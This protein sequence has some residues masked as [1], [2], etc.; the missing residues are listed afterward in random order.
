MCV[1]IMTES[2]KEEGDVA[3]KEKEARLL[4]EDELRKLKAEGF[5]R[6]NDLMCPKGTTRRKTRT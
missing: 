1:D 5:R 2:I 4:K 6:V 3:L